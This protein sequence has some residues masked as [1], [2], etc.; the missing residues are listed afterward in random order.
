LSNAGPKTNSKV[1]GGC[2][3]LSSRWSRS[4]TGVN[5]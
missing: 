4:P 5:Y 2:M 3:R 1:Y